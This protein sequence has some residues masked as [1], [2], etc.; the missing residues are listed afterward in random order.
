MGRASD[1]EL[2]YSVGH[3]EPTTKDDGPMTD[4]IS[5][6]SIPDQE[7]TMDFV[8]AS[9]PGGQHV[10][11]VS[12]AVHL[13]FD[14]KQSPSLTD[15]VRQRLIRLAGRRIDGEGVLHI[16]AGSYRS[17]HLNREDAKNRLAD[18]VAEASRIPKKRIKTK[19]SAAAKQRMLDGKRHKST[20]KSLRGRV[21]HRSDD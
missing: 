2:W 14:V 8:R 19:P 15:R 4:D 20:I 13:R 1:G 12:T 7:I 3:H 10:N 21:E 16:H 5:P 6:P 18:L 11:K 9:G 17:Q